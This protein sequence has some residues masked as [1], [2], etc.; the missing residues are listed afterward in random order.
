VAKNGL[1]SHSSVFYQA[2]LED[3]QLRQCDSKTTTHQSQCSVLSK[4]GLPTKSINIKQNCAK[5]KNAAKFKFVLKKGYRIGYKNVYIP[6]IRI[7]I[8]Q[9][10]PLKK[11]IG[12][13]PFSRF[14]DRIWDI[15]IL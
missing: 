6:K 9:H 12:E 14:L 5:E 15:Y 7:Y 8:L 3:S 2:T 10:I 13:Y 11:R 4:R 1:S